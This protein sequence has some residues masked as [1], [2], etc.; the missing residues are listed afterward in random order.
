[1]SIISYGQS[2]ELLQ[3]TKVIH[4][5]I[6]KARALIQSGN[7]EKAISLLNKTYSKTNDASIATELVNIYYRQNNG[8]KAAEWAKKSALNESLDKNDVILFARLLIQKGSYKKALDH[9]LNYALLKND[10]KGIADIA[11]ACENLI[12]SEKSSVLFNVSTVP[13][14]TNGEEVGI[15]N[16]RNNYVMASNGLSDN[17]RFDFY[18]LQQ[19]YNKWRYPEVLLRTPNAKINRTSLSYSLDGNYVYFSTYDNLSE[20]EKKKLNG[21]S[22]EFRIYFG[23]SQGNEWVE[24]DVFPYQEEGFS[25]KDPAIHPEGK[26]LVFSSNQNSKDNFDLFYSIFEN[27][28]WSKPKALSNYVNTDADEV[29]PYFAEDGSLYFSSNNKLGFG[30]FDIY[31]TKQSNGVWIRPDILPPPLNSHF[32]DMSIVF[33]YGRPGGFLVSNRSGNYDIFAFEDFNL[34][35]SVSVMSKEDG[36]LLPYS[37]V[38]LFQNDILLEEK[39]TGKDG[40]VT[41]Q[42]ASGNTY[43]ILVSKEGYIDVNKEVAASNKT[44]GG[45]FFVNAQLI[46]DKSYAIA[47]PSQ[48]VNFNNQNFIEVTA[49]FVTPNNQPVTRT[50]FKMIN[51]NSGRM[52]I[53]QTDGEGKFAQSLYIG[54]DYKL[55]IEYNNQTFEKYYS[56][57]DMKAGKQDLLFILDQAV[58]ESKID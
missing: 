25:Y 17:N 32:D 35:M 10:P 22:P 41:F 47:N 40:D 16:Y 50:S 43:K 37:V 15:T 8:E 38:Q 2:E 30:G 12:A 13:F 11:Y 46:K 19:D 7:T 23:I 31:K 57:K 39:L 18:T 21:A 55:V 4:P 36:A 28:Q 6:E 9:C 3:E 5:K 34:K 44:N 48:E 24:T 53:I 42:V 54:N 52:K 58:N 56:T 33:H 51:V 45:E 26:L 29:K 14:N 49:Q 20:K 27:H 1:M